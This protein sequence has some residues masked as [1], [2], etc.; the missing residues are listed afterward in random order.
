M[1][2]NLPSRNITN[3]ITTIVSTLVI[4][5]MQ[6]MFTQNAHAQTRPYD[7]GEIITLQ[8]SALQSDSYYNNNKFKNSSQHS[9]NTLLRY[10]IAKNYELQ[11]GWSAQ[12]DNSDIK[13]ATSESTNI[14][15]KIY[16]TKDSKFLPALSAIV[17]TNLT[18][19]PEKSPFGPSINLLFDKGLND[20]WCVNG[21]VQFSLDEQAGD[22]TNNYSFNIEAAVTDW[23]ITYVGLTGSSDPFQTDTSS[24]QQYLEIGMLFWVYDGIVLYPFYDV[25]L[26]DSSGDIF[27]IGALFTLGK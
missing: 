24:Y 9:L 20:T 17:S 25:G 14:G 5:V 10:G 6:L 16:L 18:F 11:F 22:F 19:D 27:N 7:N 23:Q 8:K 2:Y 15:V 21:N 12:K 4:L 26:N 3:Y 13:G 1:K